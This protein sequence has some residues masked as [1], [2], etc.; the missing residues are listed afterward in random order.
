M[1][2]KSGNCNL[3]EDPVKVLTSFFFSWHLVLVCSFTQ[4]FTREFGVW[5][6]VSGPKLWKL[7]GFSI[8]IDLDNEDVRFILVSPL[9]EGDLTTLSRVILRNNL[10]DQIFTFVSA[11][12]LCH[13]HRPSN[14]IVSDSGHCPWFED[15]A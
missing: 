8:L 7:H 12:T 10:K 2:D 11:F 4:S 13:I 14:L 6:S 5:K 1:N 9:A 15:F 3:A